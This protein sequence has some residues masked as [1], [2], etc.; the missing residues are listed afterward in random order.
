[1]ETNLDKYIDMLKDSG[2]ASALV[3]D[4]REVVTA[5]WTVF[6]CQFGCASYGR[7]HCCRR[8]RRP[9]IKP[10]KFSTVI[11]LPFYSARMAGMQAAWLTTAQDSYIWT[12]TTKPLLSAAVCA[13]SAGNVIRQAADS[14][15][16]LF[17]QWKPAVSMSS[18]RH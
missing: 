7:N 16:K 15:I 2:A 11:L 9:M 13:S 5:P 1:M 17:P 3:I 4:P 6:K 8:K 12:D 14:P 10:E 18:L